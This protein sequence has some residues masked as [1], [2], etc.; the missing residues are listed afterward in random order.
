MPGNMPIK[1]LMTP[2]EL[3]AARAAFGLTAAE[4]A[5]AFNVNPRTMRGWKAGAATRKPMAIPVP[6]AI[7]VRLALKNAT[8]RRELGIPAAVVG[9]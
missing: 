8:V 5:R 7:L 3:K 1:D 6:I 9:P 4:F 2:D